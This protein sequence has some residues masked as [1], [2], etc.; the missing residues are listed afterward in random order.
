MTATWSASINSRASE[1]GG[2]EFTATRMELAMPSSQPRFSAMEIARCRSDGAI[3]FAYA[4]ITTVT[5]WPATN[6]AFAASSCSTGSPRSRTSGLMPPKRVAG[7]A[8]RI[9][10]CNPE[11]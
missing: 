8:A 11:A 3:S 5:D 4:P 9:A 6:A 7:P 1:P 2:A 10:A